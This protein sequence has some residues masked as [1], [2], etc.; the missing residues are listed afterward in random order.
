VAG[1]TLIGVE[2]RTEAIVRAAGHDFDVSEARLAILE[3]GGFVRSKTC[4]SPKLWPTPNL[5]RCHIALR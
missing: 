1:E 2:A 5:G 4:G 3:E